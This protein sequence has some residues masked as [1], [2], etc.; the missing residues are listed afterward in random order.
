MGKSIAAAARCAK[1]K[2]SGSRER[3][4]N[5]PLMHSGTMAAIRVGIYNVKIGGFPLFFLGGYCWCFI[6]GHIE[7]VSLI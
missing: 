1:V 3:T 2:P 5:T 4:D 7:I 6:V